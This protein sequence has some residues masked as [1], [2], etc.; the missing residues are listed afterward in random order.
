[1]ITIEHDRDDYLVCRVTGKLTKSDYEAAVP[2]LENA[3]KISQD[4]RN[5]M[6]VLEDFDGWDAGALWEE[7][8][9]DVTHRTAFAKI[10]VVGDSGLAEWGTKLGDLLFSAE[11]R[12]FEYDQ[13][14]AAAAWLS[15]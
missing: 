6:I 3:L 2:E 12:Y 8:K 13:R 1:M 7:L 15:A 4:R 5:L 9:F 11:T 14:A 10:A